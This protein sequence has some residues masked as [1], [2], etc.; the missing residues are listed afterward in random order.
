MKSRGPR[1]L[2]VAL[3]EGVNVAL[4]IPD[5]TR[6]RLDVADQPGVPPSLGRAPV[7]LHHFAKLFIGV[8]LLNFC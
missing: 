8:S 4:E 7:N 6:R 2:F 5:L 1:F 3:I